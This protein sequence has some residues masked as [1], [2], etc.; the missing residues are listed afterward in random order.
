[1]ITF[2]SKGMIFAFIIFHT[3]VRTFDSNFIQ[4]N[5]SY[6]FNWISVELVDG[7]ADSHTKELE[8]VQLTIDLGHE[9]VGINGLELLI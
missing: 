1:M 5:Y 4:G 2:R 9:K 8:W 7:L 3:Y 6:L